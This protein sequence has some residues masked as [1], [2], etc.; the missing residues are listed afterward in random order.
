MRKL[1]M[2]LT[3]ASMLSCYSRLEP[4]KRPETAP[5]AIK[6]P[7]P[8]KPSAAPAPKK[9]PIAE[10][11]QKEPEQM[12][13]PV[14]EE[15]KPITIPETYQEAI[16]SLNEH[17]Y[18]KVAAIIEA[19]VS[20]EKRKMKLTEEE[21]K[22][23]ALYLLQDLP[24]MPK[25]QELL[26]VMPKSTI[27]LIRGVNERGVAEKIADYLMRFQES[28]RLGNLPQLD[29]NHSHVIGREWHQIDYRGEGMS[30]QRNKAHW[31]RKGVPDFRK[32]EHI[33]TYLE[34][35]SRQSFFKRIYRPNGQLPN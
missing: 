6:R 24:E 16:E 14:Q 12:P 5:T 21:G 4:A 22:N 25:C 32:A 26:E 13:G 27:E 9:E 19:R 3:A 31:S 28:M 17:G 10:P 34:W 1:A 20:Q 33:Q 35:E 8:A 7:E 15:P 29:E 30:W 23:A 2:V 11:L 18:A